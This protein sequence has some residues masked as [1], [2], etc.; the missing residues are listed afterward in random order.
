MHDLHTD[1]PVTN[2]SGRAKG[3]LR[4]RRYNAANRRSR[5]VPWIEWKKL[6]V[7]HESMFELSER[8]AGLKVDRQVRGIVRRDAGEA[9]QIDT[10]V[11]LPKWIPEICLRPGADG[12][13]RTLFRRQELRQF[14]DRLWTKN[15]RKGD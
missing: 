3:A 12:N 2:G 8:H 15:F 7:L 11:G 4:V 5:T 14:F 6:V 1:N 9:R 13:D 10:A